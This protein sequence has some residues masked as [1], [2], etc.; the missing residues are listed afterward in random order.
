MGRL[1]RSSIVETGDPTPLID[2]FLAKQPGVLAEI[3][4]MDVG[5]VVNEADARQALVHGY[6][7]V[8]TGRACIACPDWADR[9]ANGEE[10]VLFID[11]TQRKVNHIPEPLWCFPLVE[12]MIR[13]TSMAAATFKPGTF[14]EKV[15]GDAAGLT[16]CV[17]LET[18]HI[19]DIELM[20]G[21]TDDIEF[22]THFGEIRNRI[23]SA[24]SPM[25]TPFR[26]PPCRVKR[27]KSGFQN[28]A[29]IHCITAGDNTAMAAFD[30]VIVGSGGA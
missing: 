16:I 11:S 21:L 17:H 20:P 6:D 19:T 12:A 2:K 29:Q 15:Q 26:E 28:Y 18:D 10:P 22:T 8:A 7:L 13:D 5:G 25:L 1:L 24:N 4:V 27:K 14:T 30:V 3:P 23:L 9:V